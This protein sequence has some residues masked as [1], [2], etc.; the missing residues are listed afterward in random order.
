MDP[1]I[2]RDK[3]QPATLPGE[4]AHEWRLRPGLRLPN[5]N[6]PSPEP[7][8]ASQ[9]DRLLKPDKRRERPGMGLGQRHQPHH[10]RHH[11]RAPQNPA[12]RPQNEG[13]LAHRH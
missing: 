4:I 2:L 12:A 6:Q 5:G 11:R 3:I 10:S 1:P 13:P 8:P 7:R 9:L